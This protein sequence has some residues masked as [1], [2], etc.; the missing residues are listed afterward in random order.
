MRQLHPLVKKINPVRLTMCPGCYRLQ[1]S[2]GW[3]RKEL[4][5]AVQRAL[6]R[7]MTLTQGAVVESVVVEE[8]AAEPG[9]QTVQL[10][11][12][13]SPDGHSQTY[14]EYYEVLIAIQG[15]RCPECEHQKN[16]Y[17]TGIIQL[18]NPT[19]EVAAEIERMLGR[20]LT[21][22]KD[23]TGGIDYYVSEHKFVQSVARAVHE[24]FGGELTIRAQHFSYDS[25]TSKNLYRVNSCLRLP[26]FNR[27][28]VIDTGARLMRITSMGKLLKG[29][30][31]R[32]GKSFSA[33][34]RN[35][36]PLYPIFETTVV[37]N[38]PSLSILDPDDYSTVPVVNEAII[39]RHDLQPGQTV[40]I[41]RV[42]ERYYILP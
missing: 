29:I 5:E 42:E 1:T 25:L 20:A 33:P 12:I 10:T 39:N 30:D 38:S 27:G 2:G 24:R 4:Q 3:L 11:V 14:E 9:H 23:V 7:N 34:C 13:G 16:Q 37:S 22:V 8:V 32:T 35:D 19:D 41:T 31:I 17:F 26:K 36:Y 15:N 18:R 6:Q 40:A 28:S 21:S